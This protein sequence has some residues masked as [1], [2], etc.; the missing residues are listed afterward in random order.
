MKLFLK[1]V[2]TLALC[3]VIGSAVSA[4]AHVIGQVPLHHYPYGYAVPY[5]VMP[6]VPYSIGHIPYPYPYFY[7]YGITRPKPRIVDFDIN[8]VADER[9]IKAFPLSHVDR[10]YLEIK[11]RVAFNLYKQGKF[12]E[13]MEAFSDLSIYRGNYLFLYWAGMSAVRLGDNSRATEFF[14]KTLAINPYYEPARREVSL[15]R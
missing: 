11:F 12:Q 6:Y 7:S 4:E 5:P 8:T 9:L 13:A 2:L 3:F 14:N 15:G 1:A 10:N